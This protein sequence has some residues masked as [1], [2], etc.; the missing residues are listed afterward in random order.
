MSESVA[1]RN[2]PENA[3]DPLTLAD[4]AAVAASNPSTGRRPNQPPTEPDGS[5]EDRRLRTT[6]T[7]GSPASN[8]AV[9]GMGVSTTFRS[10]LQSS[11][12]G[13]QSAWNGRAHSAS[14][15]GRPP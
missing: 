15:V 7:I 13:A 6:G 3:N 4:Q 11:D 8:S 12:V 10:Y 14:V 1:E 2:Y 5:R 9:I